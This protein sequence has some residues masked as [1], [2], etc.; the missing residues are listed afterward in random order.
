MSKDLKTL[1]FAVGVPGKLTSNVW[2][3][4]VG[5]KGDV[6]LAS[7]TLAHIQKFSYHVSGICRNAFTSA[8]GTP[9]AMDDRL[10]YKWNRAQTPL[11]GEMSGSLVALLAFPSDYLSNVSSSDES[12][13]NLLWIPA[14]PAGSATYVE[15]FYTN[16]N[17]ESIH[18]ISTKRNILS[19]TKLPNLEAVCISTYFDKWENSDLKMP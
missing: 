4:W 3:F 11:A 19:Y 1:R 8:H 10:M 7:R 6:Y 2:R 15:V 16:E 18:E 17:E 13:K 9:I 14:A 12:I 5:T